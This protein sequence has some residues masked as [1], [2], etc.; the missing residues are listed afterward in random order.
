MNITESLQSSSVLVQYSLDQL[1]KTEMSM[2]RISLVPAL[3]VSD[4][5]P[6]WILTRFTRWAWGILFICLSADSLI[7]NG[8]RVFL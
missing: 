3:A 1:V 7:Q 5:D 6:S 8:P 2:Y 4:A